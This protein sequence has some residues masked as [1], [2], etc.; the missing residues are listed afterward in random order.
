ME[1]PDD[2]QGAL[3]QALAVRDV[4]VVIDITVPTS[5]KVYPMIPA[6]QSVHQMMLREDEIPVE[7]SV[8]M[9]SSRWSFAD[10]DEVLAGLL[11]EGKG[12]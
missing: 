11:D 9:D 3:E 7:P 4:P 6:G 8:D 5:G 10:D 2:L 12:K 1:T